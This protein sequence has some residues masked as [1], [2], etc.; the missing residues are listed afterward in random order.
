MKVKCFLAIM[1]AV[2]MLSV[3]VHEIRPVKGFDGTVKIGII[4]PVGLPHWSPGMWEAAQMARDEIN[5]EGGIHLSDGDYEIVLVEGNSHAYPTP[6]PPAAAAEMERLCDPAQEGV[7]FV[8]GGFRT[9]VTAAMVE[10]AAD[11]QVPF[12]IDGASTDELISETVAVDYDRYKYLFRIMPNNS[13]TLFKTFAAGLQYYL[14]PSKLLPL[15]GHDLDNNPETPPQ[16]R[17]AVITEDLEWT[18]GMH[19]A[20]TDPS[21]YPHVL[22]PN[23]NVTYAGRIPDGT[24]DCSSWLQDVKDSKARLLIHVFSGV[25]GSPFISQWASMNVSALPVGINVLGQLQTHWENTGG[26]CEYESVLNVLGTRTPITPKAVEFWD[27]FVDM[28]GMWPIYTAFGAYDG[29]YM[30]KEALEDIGSI[31]K[32]ALVTKFED[33]SYRRL[34]LNGNFSF[35]SNHDVYM[36]ES[37]LAPAG[38]SHNTTR[39]FIVQWISGRMEVV[40]PMDEPYSK[41][42]SIPPWMYPLQ[43]DLTFDGS[44]DIRD[45]ALAAKAFG[46]YPGHPRWEKEADTNFDD[47]IDIRDIAT[48]AKDFGKSVSLPLP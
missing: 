19:Y 28:T 14:V 10:V 4:G 1:F 48:I 15:Y 41:R 13:T 35:T 40:S 6:D 11:Y 46:T 18:V 33:P 16:I 30:L 2:L 22:G 21:M 12:F 5:A 32:D 23:V 42:W 9:E 31:D 24:T 37:A 27:K 7:D 43:T 26:L 8:I 45:I 20:L 34:A 29:V 44:V 47:T 39:V 38:W 36:D 25:T 3:T 17:V